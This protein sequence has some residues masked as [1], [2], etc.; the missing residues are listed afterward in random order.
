MGFL[1][2]LTACG[3]GKMTA[4]LWTKKMMASCN[5]KKMPQKPVQQ[6]AVQAERVIGGS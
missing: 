1:G 4:L 6:S 2:M 5:K 3:E